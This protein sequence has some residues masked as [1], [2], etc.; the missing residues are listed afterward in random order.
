[1]VQRCIN[2]WITVVAAPAALRASR[3]RTVSWV[4]STKT[5]GWIIAPI[6]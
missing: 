6:E 2:V 5:F 1:M 4:N 3:S